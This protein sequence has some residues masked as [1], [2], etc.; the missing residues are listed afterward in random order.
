M[1]FPIAKLAVGFARSVPG[2][3]AGQHGDEND[4]ARPEV[5]RTSVELAAEEDFRGDV[6]QSSAALGQ[7]P[8][9]VFV[10]EHRGHAEIGQLQIVRVVEKNVFRLQIAMSN[11]FAEKI[12]HGRN[13]LGK[14]ALC[15]KEGIFL[16][17]DGPSASV[18]LMLVFM[19]A[20]ER[21]RAYVRAFIYACVCACLCLC[22]CVCGVFFV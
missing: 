22:A 10:T 18:T 19:L 17:Y 3:F 6:G 7:L 13:Q 21:V 11:A 4:S 5:R 20:R 14:V 9:C 15:L 8:L 12:I 1:V 2:K 16:A